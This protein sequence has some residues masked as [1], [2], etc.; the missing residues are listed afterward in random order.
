MLLANR[1]VAK[2]AT[3]PAPLMRFHW[4]EKAG[5]VKPS[6]ITIFSALNYFIRFVL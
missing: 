1:W 5:A 2:N 6:I 4:P 3:Q